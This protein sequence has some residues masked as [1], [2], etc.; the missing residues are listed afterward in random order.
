MQDIKMLVARQWQPDQEIKL[1]NLIERKLRMTQ[2]AYYFS[3]LEMWE[4]VT[5]GQWIVYDQADNPLFTLD[6][7]FRPF[8]VY[9]C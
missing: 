2:A 3:P 7:D 4:C 9:G 6:K 8:R 1:P 5:P